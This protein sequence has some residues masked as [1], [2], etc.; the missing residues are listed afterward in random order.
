M[1]RPTPADTPA[2][3]ANRHVATERYLGRGHVN[4]Q[5]ISGAHVRA[6]VRGDQDGPHIVT[7]NTRGWHCTCPVAARL[8]R[9]ATFTNPAV[10]CFHVIAVGL[11]VYPPE[12]DEDAW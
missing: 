12:P 4:V 8:G 7:H 1:S 11:V 3:R 6:T 10:G 9:D 2:A 5:V